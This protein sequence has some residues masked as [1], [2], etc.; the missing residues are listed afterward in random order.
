LQ[1]GV[2]TLKSIAKTFGI[3]VPPET[4]EKMAFLGQSSRM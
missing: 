2:F 4:S 3:E 1:R